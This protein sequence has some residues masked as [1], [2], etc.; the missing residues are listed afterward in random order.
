MAL[1]ASQIVTLLGKQQI[2]DWNR[3]LN[4]TSPKNYVSSFNDTVLNIISNGISIIGDETNETITCD[5]SDLH[6]INSKILK[7]DK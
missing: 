4:N 2:F 5:D 3:A 6:W 7:S 1:K